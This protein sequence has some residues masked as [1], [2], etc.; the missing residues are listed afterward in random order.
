MATQMA[1]LYPE[2][3]S[4]RACITLL[5]ISRVPQLLLLVRCETFLTIV[6]TN[7]RLV[8]QNGQPWGAGWCGHSTCIVMSTC[9]VCSTCIA[10]QHTLNASRPSRIPQSAQAVHDERQGHTNRCQQDSEQRVSTV[11]V[12]QLWHCAVLCV[13]MSI[14]CLTFNRHN[15]MQ[16]ATCSEPAAC[17]SRH[18]AHA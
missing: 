12:E 9:I 6:A 5:H 15:H 3:V 1:E 8:S 2:I 4:E 11:A 7:F 18:C 17:Q 14:V 10:C 13:K 16:H